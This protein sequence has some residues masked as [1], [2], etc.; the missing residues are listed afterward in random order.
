VK[1]QVE[2]PDIDT[3]TAQ[4]QAAEAQA[5]FVSFTSVRALTSGSG[6]LS[7]GARAAKPGSAGTLD[8]YYESDTRWLY[9]YSGTAWLFLTGT[10]SG[11]DSARAAITV[12]ANDNGAL[13]I[14][15]DIKAVYQVSG[16]AWVLRFS[17]AR[18]NKFNATV[19]PTV[20]EDSGDGYEV[21]SEWID[22]TADDAY[23][24]LDATVGAAVWKKTTP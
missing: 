22:V 8:F 5:S 16:G 20:N 14:S 19:A 21:G 17:G 9:Y 13:F 23:V 4:R 11:N 2:S 10:N 15:T 1:T 3:T 7:V 6:A 24:C 12:T 18:L